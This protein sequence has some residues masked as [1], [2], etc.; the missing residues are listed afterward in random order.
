MNESAGCIP[1]RRHIWQSRVRWAAMS[2]ALIVTIVLAFVAKWQADEIEDRNQQTEAFMSMIRSSATAF[3]MVDEYGSIQLWSRGAENMFG[4]TRQEAREQGIQM[5]MPT[6]D[7]RRYRESLR[8]AVDDG[9]L[10][11]RVNVIREVALNKDGQDV[12]VYIYISSFRHR[13]SLMFFSIIEHAEQVEQSLFDH[14]RRKSQ[15]FIGNRG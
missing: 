1:T 9:G 5:L 12:P 8:A 13:G 14:E 15:Q 6:S 11:D 7:Q 3:V 4:W 2:W 10:T